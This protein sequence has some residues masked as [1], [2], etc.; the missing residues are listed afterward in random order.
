MLFAHDTVRAL[1]AAVALVNSGPALS[2]PEQLTEFVHAWAWTGAHTGSQAELV[3]VQALRPRLS[4]LWRSDDEQAVALINELLAEGRALPQ[5]TRHD[6]YGWHLHAT[7]SDA[8]LADRMAV[9]AAMAM[10]DVL[11]MG[12][13]D[14]LRTCAAADCDDVLVDLSRNRSRLFCDGGCGNRANVA[15]YRARRADQA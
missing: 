6:G 14:R 10:V 13:L 3:E 11:R 9:E 4:Q 15:A 8:P 1:T 2:T 12:E 7:P 5:L